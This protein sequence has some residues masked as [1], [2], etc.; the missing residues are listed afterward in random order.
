MELPPKLQLNDVEL[1]LLTPDDAAP[2]FA[3]VDKNRAYLRQ[4]LPWLDATKSV[5]DI[6]QFIKKAQDHLTKSEGVEFGILFRGI[7]VGVISLHNVDAANRRG[8]IGYWLDAD[9]QWKGIMTTAVRLVLRYGFGTLKLNRIKISCAVGNAKSCAIPKRL[10][11]THEGIS[12][13]YEWLY[14]HFVDINNF[15]LLASEWKE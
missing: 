3:L 14:D 4:W 8:T 7:L 13:Q 6:A 12:R 5:D 11:F 9:H 2:L 15:S 1:R 10:G